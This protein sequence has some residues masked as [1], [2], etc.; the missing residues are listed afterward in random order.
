MGERAGRAAA[1]TR[2]DEGRAAAMRR[3]EGRAAREWREGTREGGVEVARGRRGG[4]R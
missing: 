2:G 4:E 1:A 3:D